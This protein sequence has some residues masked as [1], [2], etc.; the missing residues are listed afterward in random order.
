MVGKIYGILDAVHAHR[1]FQN[2]LSARNRVQTIHSL[3]RQIFKN[4][5]PNF[6]LLLQIPLARQINLQPPGRPRLLPRTA[7]HPHHCLLVKTIVREPPAAKHSP[8]H[9]A[10]GPTD[11]R[12]GRR[13]L[14]F[15]DRDGQVARVHEGENAVVRMDWGRSEVGAGV[16]DPS[17]L[18][19]S[20]SSGSRLSKPK[21]VEEGS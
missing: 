17:G 21:G 16:A 2:P 19:P 9:A 15:K 18:E 7:R 6:P 3:L 10:L 20:R 13:P 11:Q 5:T 14:G 8:Q 12:H 1:L 4:P